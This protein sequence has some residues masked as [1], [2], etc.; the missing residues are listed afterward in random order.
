[1][2][3]LLAFRGAMRASH[4]SLV[5]SVVRTL[6]ARQRGSMR[7]VARLASV[8]SAGGSLDGAR[9]TKQKGRGPFEPRPFVAVDCLV[10]RYGRA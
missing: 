8:A 6:K 2:A 10:P 9:S 1:M 5:S 3:R 4:A 7:H